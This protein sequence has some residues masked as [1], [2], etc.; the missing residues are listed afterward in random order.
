MMTTTDAA[1][2]DHVS[3]ADNDNDV[4]KNDG[5]NNNGASPI[6]TDVVDVT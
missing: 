5:S 4:E 1:A 6:A 3:S 2:E